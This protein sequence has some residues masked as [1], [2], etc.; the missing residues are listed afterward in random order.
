MRCCGSPAIPKTSKLGTQF[1]AHKSDTCGVGGE[2][3]EHLRCKE[4]I[5]KGARDC[6]WRAEPE[7]GGQSPNGEI[8]IAD[9]LCSKNAEKIAIEVQ[10]A[11]QT[12]D[13]Y[14]QRTVRY[15]NSGIGCL[16]LI[17]KKQRNPISEPMILDRIQSKNRND[18][19]G[20]HPDRQDMPVFQVDVTEMDNMFVFFPWHH[21]N[22][23]YQIPVSD[24]ISGVLSGKMTFNEKRWCWNA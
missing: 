7:E 16:W 23:P 8:W 10:L 11:T 17:R 3:A 14:K 24:F 15:R 21:G 1:F 20:H 12:F 19:L 6:G 18:V 22:G 4:L 9:V 2:S 5:I 13:E